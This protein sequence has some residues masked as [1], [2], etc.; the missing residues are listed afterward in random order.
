M[1]KNALG[2]KPANSQLDDLESFYWVLC[3]MVCFHDGPG[4]SSSQPV[5]SPEM[6]LLVIVDGKSAALSE[7][8]HFVLPFGPFGLPLAAFWGGASSASCGIYTCSFASDFLHKRPP[9]NW[10]KTHLPT[11]WAL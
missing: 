6:N 9:M 1:C 10:N 2:G 8:N 7:R 4:L 5:M 11:T 3:F